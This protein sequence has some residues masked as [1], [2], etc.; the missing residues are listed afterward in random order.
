VQLEKAFD[1][2]NR[3]PWLEQFFHECV[4]NRGCND[5]GWM[6]AMLRDATRYIAVRPFAGLNLDA[7]LACSYHYA[8]LDAEVGIEKKVDLMAFCPTMPGVSFRLSK[9]S[10]TQTVTEGSIL[11]RDVLQYSASATFCYGP[12]PNTRKRY[13]FEYLPSTRSIRGSIT[14]LCENYGHVQATSVDG[15]KRFSDVFEPEAI[16]ISQVIHL[17]SFGEI[18]R[19]FDIYEAR[20][21]MDRLCAAKHR[22]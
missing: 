5:K 11:S 20:N 21:M 9:R 16:I 2:I 10:G 1:Y 8:V 14:E 4:K 7:N 18:F 19:S 3:F 13:R 6:T 12:F 15:R 22:R 17:R